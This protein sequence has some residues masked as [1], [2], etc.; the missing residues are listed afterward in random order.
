MSSKLRF[1]KFKK[2]VSRSL[3]GEPQLTQTTLNFRTSCWNLKIGGLRFV[4]LFHYFYI[5]RN[6]GVL[7]SK[8]PCFLLNKNINEI[9]S[10]MV[11]PILSFREMTLCFSSNKNGEIKVKRWWVGACGRI[12]I[13]LHIKRFHFIPLRYLFLK[14]S[15]AF[16]VSLSKEVS[17][18]DFSS[19]WH[20]GVSHKCGLWD[21]VQETFSG[22]YVNQQLQFLNKGTNC[23]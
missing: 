12:Y 19:S 18:S 21:W 2:F 5:E 3:F 8:S 14:S 10:K 1:S 22:I 6:S 13:L 20:C 17:T 23:G 11:N 15:K 7:K 4:W 9:Q 16:S